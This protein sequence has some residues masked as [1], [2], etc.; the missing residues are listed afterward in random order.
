MILKPIQ[1]S[2]I[3]HAGYDPE[4]ETAR[5]VFKNGGAFD[6]SGVS[7]ETFSDMV[8]AKSV[9]KFFHSNIRAKHNFKKVE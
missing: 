3:T 7:Q 6:Y 8:K 9:G 5:V 2:N 1:S 4:S